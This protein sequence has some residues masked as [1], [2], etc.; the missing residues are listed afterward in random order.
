[1]ASGMMLP[2]SGTTGVSPT[3][4]PGVK[5]EMAIGSPPVGGISGNIGGTGQVGGGTSASPPPSPGSGSGIGSGSGV[6]F[7]SGVG[8]G[9]GVGCGIGFGSGSGFE[10]VSVELSSFAVFD[11]LR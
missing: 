10:M 8:V 3:P 6:G 2:G 1:M 9:V 5:S 7:G 11:E 4:V